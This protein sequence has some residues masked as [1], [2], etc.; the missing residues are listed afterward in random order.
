VLQVMSM[1]RAG[2]RSLQEL[3][4]GLSVTTRTVRRDLDVLEAAHL[5]ITKGRDD[6]SGVA[7]WAL[8]AWS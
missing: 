2:R 4:D 5:P 7:Y 6:L 8:G 1:L 3:A